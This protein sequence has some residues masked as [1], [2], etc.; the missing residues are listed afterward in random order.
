MEIGRV[1]MAEA[2]EIKC[3][4]IACYETACGFVLRPSFDHIV[5]LRMITCDR[6]IR[7]LVG[8]R[9]VVDNRTARSADAVD[10]TPVIDKVQSAD[11]AP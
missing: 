8:A 1:G 11:D 10:Q 4:I 9:W 7:V 6:H 2:I 5:H 3:K